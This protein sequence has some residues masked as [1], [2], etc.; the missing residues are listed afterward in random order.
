MARL[1]EL[2]AGL[3]AS[4]P[5]LTAGQWAF[6]NEATLL[7]YLAY[8]E[9]KGDSAGGGA[10][11]GGSASP[12]GTPG[13]PAGGSGGRGGSSTVKKTLTAVL[14]DPEVRSIEE[15]CIVTLDDPSSGGSGKIKERMQRRMLQSTGVSTSSLQTNAP[16]GLDRIDSRSGGAGPD[17]YCTRAFEPLTPFSHSSDLSLAYQRCPASLRRPRIR[18]HHIARKTPV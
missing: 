10:A 7:R 5:P 13:S 4:S 8:Y 14:A 11:G 6:C 15:N 1:P 18:G 16:W 3:E 9:I 2:R 17:L 12:P